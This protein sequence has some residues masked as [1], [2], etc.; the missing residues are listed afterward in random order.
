LLEIFHYVLAGFAAL[1][2]S[3]PLLHV[4]VGLFLILAPPHMFD[5]G[6]GGDFSPAWIGWM[7]V[8]F[9]GAFV[10]FGW[11]I[12]IMTL[13]S[14]RYLAHRRNRM[15]SLVI[16]GVQCMFAPFGTAL[17]VFTIIVLTRD[18]VRRQYPDYPNTA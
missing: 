16:A 15:F 17:G 8:V 12:A 13:I 11:S 7:F 9:G 2:G 5:D 14:G 18:S 6:S 3:F 10:L 4:V 1:W